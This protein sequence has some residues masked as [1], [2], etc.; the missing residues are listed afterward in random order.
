LPDYI[1]ADPRPFQ[2]IEWQCDEM[3]EGGS[4]KLGKTVGGLDTSGRVRNQDTRKQ[5]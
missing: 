5:P 1:Q 4:G 2:M 3:L